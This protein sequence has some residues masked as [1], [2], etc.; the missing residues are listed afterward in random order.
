MRIEDLLAQLRR[1]LV[2]RIQNGQLT[3]RSLARLTQLSQPHVHHILKGKRGLTPQIADKFLD[4]LGIDLR[5]FLDSPTS[6]PDPVAATPI[7]P[8]TLAAPPAPADLGA[9]LR[10]PLLDGLLGPEDPSPENSAIALHFPFPVML[11]EDATQCAVAR[12]G[13]DPLLQAYVQE[14]DYVV[15]QR[16]DTLRRPPPA[17]PSLSPNGWIYEVNEHWILDPATRWAND[18]LTKEA[19]QGRREWLQREGRVVG[20]LLWLIREFRPESHR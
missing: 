6:V 17:R 13:A 11:V 8:Q 20:Q 15:L 19:V 1:E 10:L 9:V 16:L 5:L 7:T 18:D 14:G 3:E 12:L 2:T 4:A